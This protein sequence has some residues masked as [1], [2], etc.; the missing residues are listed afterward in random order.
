MYI[1][2]THWQVDGVLENTETLLI[3]VME[4]FENFEWTTN[5]PFCFLHRRNTLIY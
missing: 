2:Y 5:P 3:Q 4:N 1:T